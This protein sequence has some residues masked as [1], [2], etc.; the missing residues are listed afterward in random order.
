M[1]LAFG[2]GEAGWI[3]WAIVFEVTA[4]LSC[5]LEQRRSFPADAV[6]WLGK[7][8]EEAG[9]RS[10]CWRPET[11][12]TSTRWRETAGLRCVVWQW[13]LLSILTEEET[14][15]ILVMPVQCV[16][17]LLLGK[18]LVLLLPDVQVAYVVKPPLPLL[19]QTRPHRVLV[20]TR[21]LGEMYKVIHMR[22]IAHELFDNENSYKPMRMFV[23]L[24]VQLNAVSYVNF[25]SL[26]LIEN[27]WWDSPR[28]CFCGSQ[29]VRG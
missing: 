16:V 7:L 12:T 9:L 13:T 5:R 27:R 19:R 15:N 1:F 21:Q 6:P 10:P 18:R 24:H 25:M 11:H 28:Y 4:V 8:P 26:G 17:M 20:L 23:N 2:L 29:F 22:C 14:I 3:Y